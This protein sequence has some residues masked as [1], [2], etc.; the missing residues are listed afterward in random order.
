MYKVFFNERTV[1]LT[2]D[3]FRSFQENQGLFYKFREKDELKELLLVFL[4]LRKISQLFICHPDTEKLMEVF[5]SCFQYVEAAGGLV[6][7]GSG[8]ILFINRLDKWDLP[9]GK[10]D[11]NETA[12]EAALRE[13][14]EECGIDGLEIVEELQPTYH[15]YF[16]KTV[17][18][19]KKTRWFEMVYKGTQKPKPQ[20]EEFI[21]KIIWARE[22]DLRVI[23]KNT[24]ASIMDLLKEAK[25]I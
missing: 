8:E 24:Y 6:R 4:A 21:T 10:I 13:V 12:S 5:R 15:T 18:Y 17:P 22:K 3:F 14:R 7:N 23:R 1:F 16:D 25:V 2:H 20:T 11:G 9:K 19:L